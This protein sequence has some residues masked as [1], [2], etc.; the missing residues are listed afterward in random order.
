M[1]RKR[2]TNATIDKMPSTKEAK[3]C[4]SGTAKN[5]P[6]DARNR[7]IPGPFFSRSDMNN[8]RSKAF[9]MAESPG[10]SAPSSTVAGA[11]KPILN[12]HRM[13]SMPFTV[14][15]AHTAA[16]PTNGE[17][18][19]MISS[20]GTSGP[21]AGMILSWTSIAYFSVVIKVPP[22]VKVAG[23][24]ATSDVL[25]VSPP[26]SSGSTTIVPT[27]KSPC[28]YEKGRLNGTS[29]GLTVFGGPTVAVKWNVTGAALMSTDDTV[30]VNKV[31][32]EREL[33][34]KCVAARSVANC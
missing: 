30:N 9:Q 27:N 28:W 10:I 34:T 22:I 4:G 26:T 11:P 18:P 1:R 32:K 33:P 3:T 31:A 19:T 21:S 13:F 15:G 16:A 2:P 8:P 5:G 17:Q 25:L 24:L 29:N 20:W 7:I 14:L 12:P 6:T 23:E